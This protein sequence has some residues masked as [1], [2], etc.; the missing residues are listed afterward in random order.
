MVKRDIDHVDKI[1]KRPAGHVV[2]RLPDLADSFILQK[3]TRAGVINLPSLTPY[4]ARSKQYDPVT[5]IATSGEL[6]M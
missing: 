6:H 3:S 2:Q 1:I 4:Y 5:V